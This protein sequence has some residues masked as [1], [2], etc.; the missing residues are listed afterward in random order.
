MS[1]RIKHIGAGRGVFCQPQIYIAGRKTESDHK[2][3]KRELYST[4]VYMLS[5]FVSDLWS[6]CNIRHRRNKIWLAE[7]ASNPKSDHKMKKTFDRGAT[8]FLVM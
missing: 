3:K 5:F 1:V 2:M 7:Q 8:M 6:E 4:I